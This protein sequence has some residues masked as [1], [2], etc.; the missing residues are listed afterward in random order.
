MVPTHR[1][2]G[3]HPVGVAAAQPSVWYEGPV[4]MALIRALG[5]W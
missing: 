3:S 2:V 1:A 4:A 5:P